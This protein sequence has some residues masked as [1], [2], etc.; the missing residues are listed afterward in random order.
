MHTY[1]TKYFLRASPALE[2]KVCAS[3]EGSSEKILNAQ[4]FEEK[5]VSHR[6]QSA[7]F[8]K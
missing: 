2:D 5:S 3:T 4:Y 8:H 7:E 1:A 6:Y